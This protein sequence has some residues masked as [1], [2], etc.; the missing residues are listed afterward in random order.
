MKSNVTNWS[1]ALRIDQRQQ[2][3]GRRRGAGFFMRKHALAIDQDFE[4]TDG[5]TYPRPNPVLGLQ[6]ALEAHGRAS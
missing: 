5:M 3:A 2:F 4:F 6:F 1:P